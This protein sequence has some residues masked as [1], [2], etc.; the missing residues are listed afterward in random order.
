MTQVT[1]RW[2]ASAREAAGTSETTMPLGG[3]A[4]AE[5]VLADA[6]HGNDRLQRIIGVASLLADGAA[7]TDRSAPLTAQTL[8]VLPPFAGG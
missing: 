1:I 4:T 6:A 7:L 5:A 2:F 8:D 3:G